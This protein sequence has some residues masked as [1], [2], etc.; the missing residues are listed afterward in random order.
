MISDAQRPGTG[1]RRPRRMRARQRPGFGPT[2]R[3][4]RRRW[5]GLRGSRLPRSSARGA[6][7][8][9][10]VILALAIL[11]G[12]IAV[13]GELGR[14]GMENARFAREIT[15][16]QLLCQSKMA[17]ITAGLLPAEA[18]PET[19]FDEVVGDGQVEWQYSIETEPTD[20]D[21]LIA[22]RVNVRQNLEQQKRPV[23][24]SLVRWVP[25]PAVQMSGM[26]GSEASAT[27]GA[28]SGGSGE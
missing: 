24:F 27:A 7:S 1:R 14:L 3:R 17:E 6:F 9:L 18:V 23:E 28:Q 22:V 16:A 15:Q 11:T 19:S 21:G 12:A 10:E 8:L 13:L 20:V 5:L 25:D 26:T 4:T 2:D